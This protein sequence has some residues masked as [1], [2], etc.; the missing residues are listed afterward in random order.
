MISS[1]LQE[2]DKR[3]VGLRI[4]AIRAKRTQ[5]SFAA[6][7]EVTQ[8]YISD[9]ERGKC[10][11]SVAF[12]TRLRAVSRKSFDWILTGKERAAAPPEN[13]EAD[14]EQMQNTFNLLGDAPPPEKPRFAKL[15][16]VS[17]LDVM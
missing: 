4:R 17:L 2:V 9:L 16:I 1:L 5:T 13:G 15:L 6:L 7:M 12:L 10:F 14:Y 3:A 11:P 8:S